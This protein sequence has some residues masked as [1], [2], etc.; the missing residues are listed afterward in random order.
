MFIVSAA[1]FMLILAEERVPWLAE[2]AIHW[3][4]TIA[5]DATVA[6]YVL[7]TIAAS[8]MTVLSVVYSVLLLVLTF[9]SIQFSPRIIVAFMKDRVSQV[10]LGAFLGTFVV[11]LL[12]MASIR[13]GPPPLVPTLAVTFAMALAA[14]ALLCLLYFVHNMALSIQPNSIVQRIA[15]ETEVVIDTLFDPDPDPDPAHPAGDSAL[16]EGDGSTL[17]CFSSGYIQYLDLRVLAAAA[18]AH[19][20]CFRM[21][22]AIGQFVPKGGAVAL[23]HPAS[24]ASAA[25]QRAALRAFHVAAVRTMESDV[26]FGVLQIVDIALKAVSPAVNDPTTAIACVDYLSHIL[27]MA[28]TKR[29]PAT[30]VYDEVGVLRIVLKRTS[31]P[32]LLDMAFDQLAHYAKTDMAVCLRM[33]RALRDVADVARDPTHLQAIHVRAKGV[34]DLCS[35]NFSLEERA[36]LSE[37]MAQIDRRTSRPEG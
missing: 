32:R 5:R 30:R 26:E 28:A 22:R 12:T 23:V 24:R 7:S 8:I 21:T 11:C 6:Q 1:G 9:A 4:W 16:A 2:R 35:K 31:F 37:R 19:D 14:A 18:E 33:L 20:V 29:P 15:L 25:C 13:T 27:T 17:S 3:R 34:Y 36:E 10:T